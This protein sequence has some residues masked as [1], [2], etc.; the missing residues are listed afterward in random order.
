M[1]GDKRG[2][3]PFPGLRPFREGE[4]ALFFG[5]EAQVDA[6][7]DKLAATRFLAVVGTSGSGKSSLVNCGL[8]PAL[9]RGLMA[10]AGSL[11]RVAT[12]RPG[13]RPLRALA[14]ALSRPGI[15]ASAQTDD[16]GFAPA[17]LMEATLRMSKLGLVDAFE[18][19]H[20]GPKQNL[21]VVVDQFEELFRYRA[22][23]ASAA[24]AGGAPPAGD[25]GDATA[26]VNLLLEAAAH[27]ALPLHVVLTMRSDFLGDCA[28]YFGLPEAINRGQYLVPRMT[29]DERRS[30]IAGPVGVS[31][32]EIDPVLLTRLVNDVGDDPDQL[33]ILQHALNRTWACWQREGGH[34]ALALPQY[35][36]VGTMAR[37]LDEH[38]EEAF[39]ALADAPQRARAEA[40][41]KAITDKG[42]DARGT[43]RPTRMDTLAEVT[44]ASLAELAAVI[45]VFRD[46]ARSFLM[47]PAGTPLAPETPLD[48]SHESL[49]RVWQRLRG[50]VDQE[51]QSA[52]T[53]RRLV[54]TA[55]LHGAGR[56]GLLRPPDLPFTLDWRE[57]ERP[58]EAW[59]RRYRSGFTAAMDFLQ[60]S[61]QA[62]DDE[63]RADRAA[64]A[65]RAQLV[66]QQQRTRRLL[67]LATAAASVLIA[68][69]S[70][71]WWLY[72]DARQ[73]RDR[74]DREAG[75][76]RAAAASSAESERDARAA[77]AVAE[78]ALLTA[79]RATDSQKNQSEIYAQALSDK[80]QLRQ[81]IQKAVQ[82]RRA[83]YLQYADSD[84]Q[85][86]IDR[87]RAQLADA[88]YSA[89]GSERV[90]GAPAS[91][92]L[93]YFRPDDAPGARDLAELLKGWAWGV[94]R[95]VYV[96]GYEGQSQ[97][98][99]FEV[100]LARSNPAD[101]AR[102][103][104]LIDG[105]NKDDRLRSL[106]TLIDSHSASPA[107]IAAALA[108]LAPPRIEALSQAGRFNLLYYLSR[109]APLAWNDA[110]IANA[111]ETIQRLRQRRDIGKE[112]QDEVTRLEGLVDAAGAGG[113][114]V[115]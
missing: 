67:G 93:R 83:V 58:T 74:A 88:G 68:M 55:E 85:A 101:T 5:R 1:N 94:V 91:A 76:A 87:L 59:A 82:G 108:M 102:L 61:Q 69:F 27:P 70:A 3:N 105:P 23:A 75:N 47:P 34:G 66:H 33:S 26:F 73:E 98:R 111:R 104:Q 29:R 16:S 92:E 24:R 80:P 20:L 89:P 110:S 35:E 43:R 2:P 4:E 90:Q 96:K 36:A 38:A 64:S 28:Q 114:M 54:E 19:A 17:E 86:A 18:Q 65:E 79:R 46:P 9:H 81:T 22:L 107:A 15:L 77:Q 48:I 25:S 21:L 11:W 60:R 100:W 10:S 62:F 97:I 41:F 72:S 106:Q 112:S 99:Q 84:Q 78:A 56:A 109:T 71:M 45:E 49:M 40:L 7:I 103:L 53:Y 6:M 31:G 39:A 30:A 12:L 37:A 115:R 57:R 95:P 42:T 8:V 113:A 32:A 52:Q 63:V 14:E 13:N 50:W 51:A 44:G